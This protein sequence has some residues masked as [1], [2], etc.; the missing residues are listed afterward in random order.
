MGRKRRKDPRYGEGLT[1]IDDSGDW[2][3]LRLDDGQTAFIAGFLMSETP[4]AR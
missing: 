1:V 3:E 2:F 4:P